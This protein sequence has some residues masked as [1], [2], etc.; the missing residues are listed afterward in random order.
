MPYKIL[1][2]VKNPCPCQKKLKLKNKGRQARTEEDRQDSSLPQGPGSEA[3][4]APLSRPGN[5][6]L[7]RAALLS[8]LQRKGFVGQ[9]AGGRTSLTDLRGDDGEIWNGN[10]R[11]EVI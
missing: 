3:A 4:S 8:V 10:G 1:L 11:H 9:E 7:L 2:S 5:P 6:R